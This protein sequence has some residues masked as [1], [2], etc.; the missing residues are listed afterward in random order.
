MK[1]RSR[2][3]TSKRSYG[4]KGRKKTK[5]LRKYKVSRGGIRL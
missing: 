3:H 4:K 1:K 5:T 2:R